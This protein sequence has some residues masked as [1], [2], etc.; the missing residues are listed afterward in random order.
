MEGVGVTVRARS[1]GPDGLESPL[2]DGVERLQPEF[3][4]SKI[5]ELLKYPAESSMFV[6]HGR[7]LSTGCPN[8]RDSVPLRY[9]RAYILTVFSE[10]H[11]YILFYTIWK[12]DLESPHFSTAIRCSHIKEQGR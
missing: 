3:Y 2:D 1:G 8:L 10:V 11:L 12:F 7:L 6:G 5:D 4:Y 9:R